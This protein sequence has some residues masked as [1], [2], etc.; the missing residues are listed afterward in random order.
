MATAKSTFGAD[1]PWIRKM[2]AVIA[3]VLQHGAEEAAGLAVSEEEEMAVA[4]AAAVR[5]AMRTRRSST[6]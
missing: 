2:T 5:R 4:V 3:A 6:H 1:G